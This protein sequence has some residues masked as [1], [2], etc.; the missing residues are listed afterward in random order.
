MELTAARKPLKGEKKGTFFPPFLGENGS[1]FFPHEL[2]Y[3]IAQTKKDQRMTAIALIGLVI[4]NVQTINIV[5]EELIVLQI[6]TDH[7]LWPI[8]LHDAAKYL[9]FITG[10][11]HYEVGENFFIPFKIREQFGKLPKDVNFKIYEP[12]WLEPIEDWL[13]REEEE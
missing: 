3:R 10:N 9:D 13:A 4:N 6:S 7:S 12:F 11:K 2:M 5:I 8:H 1:S